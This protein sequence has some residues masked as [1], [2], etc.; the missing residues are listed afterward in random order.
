MKLNFAQQA[1]QLVDLQLQVEALLSCEAS[2]LGTA[3][4]WP[5]DDRLLLTSVT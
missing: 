5:F 1:E 3:K 4:T 2:F